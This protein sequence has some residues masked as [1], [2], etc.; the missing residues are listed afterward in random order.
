MVKTD[1]SVIGQQKK[2]Q[3]FNYSIIVTSKLQYIQFIIHFYAMPGVC[4][5]LRPGIWLKCNKNITTT[6]IPHRRDS[7]KVRKL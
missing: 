4:F 6:T 1:D 7:K 5:A 2:N 3:L